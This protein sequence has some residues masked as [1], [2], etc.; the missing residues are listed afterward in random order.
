MKPYHMFKP[1]LCLILFCYFPIIALPALATTKTTS[2][3][4]LLQLNSS[5]HVLG[6]DKTGVI[7]AT[8]SHALKIKFMGT[9]GVAP[10][11]QTGSGENGKA[12]H[13][14]EVSYP[15]L[16]P[17]VTLAYTKADGGIFE[18]VYYVA[19]Y[20]DVNAISLQ[21]NTPVE[22]TSAGSLVLRFKTGTMKESA[23]VAWQ[24]IKGKR[25]PVTVSFCKKDER[26]AGFT[27]SDHDPSLP[28]IIDPVLVWNTFLGST[29]SD[30]GYGIAVD[31]S[32]NVYVTGRSYA[33]W[34]TPVNAHSGAGEY[35]SFVAKLDTK[36][37]MLWNT[38]LGSTAD[39][40]GRGI[41][42]DGSGNVYVTGTSR[43]TWGAP[44]SAFL[45]SPEVF[46]A[47]LNSNGH[48]LWNTFLGSMNSDYG[49]G[50]TVDLSNN[51]YVTGSSTSFWG[52]PVINGHAGGYYDAF[53]AKLSSSGA[54]QW[55]TFM[56][57]TA[58]DEGRSITTDSSGDV[59]VTGYSSATWGLPV[60]AHAGGND[61]FVARLNPIG[62]LQW[63]TFMVATDRDSDIAVD[64]FG[65][66]YVACSSSVSWGTPVNAHS[67][68]TDALVAKLN[69]SGVLQWHTFMGGGGTN[70]DYGFGVAVDGSNS[71]Y[72]SGISLNSW[73]TPIYNHTG[74]YYDGFV[75]GLDSS[76]VLQWNTFIGS[77]GLDS[78]SGIAV[79]GLGNVYAVGDSSASW[80]TPVS[81][82]A[83]GED[84]FVASLGQP[85][86][87]GSLTVSVEPQEARGAGA[88]WRIHGGD[89]QDS[90]ATLSLTAGKYTV[91]FSTIA[92][93]VTPRNR[94]VTIQAGQ[95]T[96]ITA[97]Y[98]NPNAHSVIT[99][100]IVT[101]LLEK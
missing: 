68:G 9:D 69:S 6:F 100:Q 71:V 58:S 42:V 48:L 96:T 99:P 92:G 64:N 1:L 11:A 37:D 70:S 55:N 56:G 83:G 36:G 78:S 77:T 50:I 80:G 101:I 10:V 89:W 87:P 17:G 39:D 20:G 35:D 66:I 84:V 27:V 13:F 51:V 28:L 86:L 85:V 22:L 76:G 93:W 81:A 16:W 88:Q 7:V 5:G 46:V 94:A 45:G 15:E 79:D 95:E 90:D 43:A 63:N 59:Y 57:S 65:S 47:K 4:Q 53:V 31:G 33:T 98:L 41:S 91:E 18:S 32:G 75:A 29:D 44:L 25:V 12:I 8:G 26:E 21:Y 72:V 30:H 62:T 38:F 34:G 74:G 61:L 82:H 54:L 49:W 73:G 23:P 60:N 14:E 24:E 40:Y 2:E 3:N 52:Q 67:G 19:P 97:T